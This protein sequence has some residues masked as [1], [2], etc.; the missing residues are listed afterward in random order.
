MRFDLTSPDEGVFHVAAGPLV[1]A[2]MDSEP[3][4]SFRP[5]ARATGSVLVIA[6]VGL[7]VDPAAARYELAPAARSG[8]L[9]AAYVPAQG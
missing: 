7:N 9:A 3:G 2:P 4:D 8:M 6:G 1:I 5:Y